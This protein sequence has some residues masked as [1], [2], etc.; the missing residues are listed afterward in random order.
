MKRPRAAHLALVAVVVLT[1][2]LGAGCSE[3]PNLTE[4]APLKARVSTRLTELNKMK[5]DGLCAES[6]SGMLTR[7]AT[8]RLS[9]EHRTLIEEENF[10]RERIFDAI[11]RAYSLPVADIKSLFAEMQPAR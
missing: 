6:A 7:S 11:S 5:S 4:I 2:F 1:A 8:A 9:V 3:K 10:D